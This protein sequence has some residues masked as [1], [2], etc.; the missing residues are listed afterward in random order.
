MSC[1][2][3]NL[4]RDCKVWSCLTKIWLICDCVSDYT[5]LTI[6]LTSRMSFYTDFAST[7]LFVPIEPL[8]W[9]TAYS[10]WLIFSSI[11]AKLCRWVSL[12]VCTSPSTWFSCSYSS[13]NDCIAHSAVSQVLWICLP[14]LA[15]IW[16]IYSADDCD[17]CRQF[18]MSLDSLSSSSATLLFSC[19]TNSSVVWYYFFKR[20]FCLSTLSFICL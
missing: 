8:V 11:K 4:L 3:C 6:N 15:S 1:F 14:S 18:L 17:C 12:S 19:F 7:L 2:D 13:C 16:T 10:I 20:S 5:W 9:C